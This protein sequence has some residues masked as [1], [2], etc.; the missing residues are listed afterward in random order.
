MAK[1]PER[2]SIYDDDAEAFI[3]GSIVQ[4]PSYLAQIDLDPE[5]FFI[6]DYRRLFEAI[7]ALREGGEEI[8]QATVAKEA[9]GKVGSWVMDRVVS[10]S[11]PVDC[12][13]YAATVKEL[14]RQ[15]RLVGAVEQA[16]RDFRKNHLASHE[17]ADKLRLA[18]D[19]LNLPTKSSR[20]IT[21]SNPR[22]IQAQPPVYELTVA[23]TN[24]KTTADIK[25]S[26]AELDK[27]S[28]F[29]R[30]VREHLQI[31]PLLPKQFDAFI[32]NILQQARVEEGQEDA[33]FDDSI[34]FWIREWFNTA[35]E[36]ENIGDLN[37]G[38]VSRDGAR[39]FSAERL[40]RFISERGKLK[41]DRSAFWSVIHNRGGRKS[42][43]FRLGN[44]TVR[45]W[46]L[47]ESFFSEGEPA[48]GDQ[49]EL[50]QDELKWLEE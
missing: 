33:G 5:D 10:E 29:R 25:I 46:G 2:A 31:N 47:D 27:P 14:S 28:V 49:L 34:C 16:L 30:H 7:L 8:N 20:T 23:T 4:E 37:L 6:E 32:H 35:S 19:S 45:L 18:A 24:G 48:E 15:R 38:Y 22:I 39:W 21:V 3:I 13:Q 12:L 36:A 43:V 40:L 26:S 50:E 9:S 17:L 11:L 1:S 41:L 42:R 44:K